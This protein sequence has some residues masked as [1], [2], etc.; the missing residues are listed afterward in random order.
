MKKIQLKSAGRDTCI[1]PGDILI[2]KPFIPEE[3]YRRTVV[4][5]VHHDEFNTTGLILNRPS[6]VQV[7]SMFEMLPVKNSLHIGGPLEPHLV[8]FVHD[9]PGFH[10]ALPIGNGLFW[11]G[12]HDYLEKHI[13]HRPGMHS[14]LKFFA[15]I[16]SWKKGQCENELQHEYWWKASISA[17]EFFNTT[18]PDIRSYALLRDDN[19]FGVLRDTPDPVMN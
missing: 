2:A 17:H 13:I 10:E 3:Q 19:L 7:S 4:L 11:G 9:I 15:G 18:I 14:R 1:R 16:T 8:T 5:I 6:I 12:S